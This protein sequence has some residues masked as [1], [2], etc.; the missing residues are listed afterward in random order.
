LGIAFRCDDDLRFEIGEAVAVAAHEGV[1]PEGVEVA[2]DETFRFGE[3]AEEPAQIKL[4]GPDGD[5]DLVAGEEGDGGSDAVDRGTIVERTFEREAE[6]FLRAAADGDDDV[7]RMKLVEAID[8]GGVGD[9]AAAI[10]RSHVDV[11][12]GD[13]DSLLLEPRE[14]ALGAG[15]A[16]HNPEGVAGLAG[17]GLL[18]KFAKVFEAGE[19]PDGRGLDSVPDED[20]EGGVGEDE[21]GVEERVAIAGVAVEILEGRRRGDDE[22]TAVAHDLDGGFGGAVEEVDAENAVSLVQRHLRHAEVILS[23]PAPAEEEK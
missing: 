7:L 16:R 1:E 8:E 10:N 17:V 9:G 5:V 6:P 18:E 14:I 2:R 13:G 11:V 12:F 21:V 15:G 22:E 20:H 19:P 3:G 23:R 4:V